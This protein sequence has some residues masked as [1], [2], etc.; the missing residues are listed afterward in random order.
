MYFLVTRSSLFILMLFLYIIFITFAAA[1]RA[2]IFTLSHCVS[3]CVFAEPQ[4][5]YC[6]PLRLLLV[7]VVVILVA[8]AI[9]KSIL[10]GT[11]LAWSNFKMCVYMCCYLYYCNLLPR[12]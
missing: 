12:L 7:L 8:T 9:P 5:W 6:T 4:R 1:W 11:G 2:K 3:V 10:L